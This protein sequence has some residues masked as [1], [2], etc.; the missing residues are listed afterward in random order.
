[1]TNGSII[2]QPKRFQLTID[3][4]CHQIIESFDPLSDCCMIG[5]QPRGT[6]LAARLK[7]RLQ[8]LTPESTIDYGQLDITFYRDDFRTRNKPLKANTT[9]MD[10]LV[11]DRN[12]VLVDDVLYTGRTVT[13]ALTALQHYGRP[14][15]VILLTMVDRRFNREVP[16][17]ADLVGMQVDAV[18]EAYVK[19]EWQEKDGEDRILIFPTKE[20]ADD[21]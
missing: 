17:E 6:F 10:F 2:L 12:V 19:V 7:E 13:A 1:M 8:S 15:K 21:K 4:L 20:D 11:E 18:D 9:S 3:R 5:I 16:V 14:R